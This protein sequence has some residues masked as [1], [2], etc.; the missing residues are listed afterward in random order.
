VA[1]GYLL[2]YG[3]CV[4]CRIL[5]A[6]CALAAKQAH[7]TL[8]TMER[9]ERLLGYMSAHPSGRKIYRASDMIL[10]VL[11]DASYLSRPN[12]GSVVGSFHFLGSSLSD[13]WINHPISAHS[14]NIP[15]ECSFVAESEYAGVFAAAQIA[16][17]ERT[18]LENFG[19]PQPPTPLYCDN[20]CAVGIANSSVTQKMSKSLDM[21]L[22]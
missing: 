17:D 1:V 13:S 18:I 8:G 3:R 14:T 16:T 6:T 2:Y 15:V 22:H 12:A 9:L 5:T 4:D 7:P 20:E 21:R 19:H 11:S 10:R